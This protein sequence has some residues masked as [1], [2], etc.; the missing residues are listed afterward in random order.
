VEGTAALTEASTN[1]IDE[2][3]KILAALAAWAEAGCG[4]AFVLYGPC[5]VGKRTLIDRFMASEAAS[6]FQSLHVRVGPE[7]GV[8]FA[9]DVTLRLAALAIPEEAPFTSSPLAVRSRVLNSLWNSEADESDGTRPLLLGLS[10]PAASLDGDLPGRHWCLAPIGPAV[11]WILSVSGTRSEAEGWLEKLELP[12]DAVTWA[13]FGAARSEGAQTEAGADFQAS[14]LAVRAALER[15]GAERLRDALGVLAATFAPLTFEE[16]A[17]LLAAEPVAL[18]ADFAG[19][20]SELTQLLQITSPPER[21]SFRHP[22]AR[23]AWLAA[24][25]ERASRQNRRLDQAASEL[26]GRASSGLPGGASTCLHRQAVTRAVA[27]SAPASVLLGAC[28]PAF[29]WPSSSDELVERRSDLDYARLRARALLAE[30]DL[31]ASATALLAAVEL[32]QGALTSVDYQGLDETLA[33]FRTWPA[34]PPSLFAARRSLARAASPALARELLLA[35]ARS[36]L[37][38]VEGWQ[39]PHTPELLLELA[40]LVEAGDRVRVARLAVSA[41]RAQALLASRLTLVALRFLPAAEAEALLSEA[42]ELCTGADRPGQAFAELTRGSQKSDPIPPLEPGE[43][44]ALYRAA[45][46]LPRDSSANALAALFPVLDGAARDTALAA[47]HA[48][49]LDQ[50]ED[51]TEDQ[52]RAE[53]EDD[54]AQL[55]S[56]PQTPSER[57]VLEYVDS[58]YCSAVV[59]PFLSP[60]QLHALLNGATWTWMGEALLLRVA[61]EG[62]TEQA[63]ERI[64]AFSSKNEDHA[65]LLLRAAVLAENSELMVRAKAALAPLPI[66]S[67]LQ[68]VADYPQEMLAVLGLDAVTAIASNADED[69]A[70]VRTRAL[71]ALCPR[72]PEVVRPRLA[73]LLLVAFW[74]D[75]GLDALDAVLQV[76]PWLTPQEALSLYARTLDGGDGLAR[77]LDG[78]SG[79]GTLAP[80][81]AR[82]GGDA[83]ITAVFPV[84]ELAERWLARATQR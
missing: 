39:S 45:R 24:D 82:A 40:T 4:S 54:V 43:I 3:A 69:H 26:L 79:V 16:L 36:A 77:A 5:G 44:E 60:A 80:L 46:V 75:G 37:S 53:E 2:Q 20:N 51:E 65:R 1:S 76:A 27:A 57:P 48:A 83:L 10:E 6:V 66:A 9:R 42:I 50:S 38:N 78:W 68:L 17:E 61:T 56:A 64:A 74:E 35:T 84:L 15:G 62:D 59:V 31:V 41:L 18:R 29:A 23:T 30:P 21:L 81:L 14:A 72:V 70:Y 47:I 49:L 8:N 58:E 34:T 22:L 67:A 11:A 52:T 33:P 73:A 19:R 63:L 71:Q 25:P 32:A 12:S 7:Q 13:S 28:E 55:S